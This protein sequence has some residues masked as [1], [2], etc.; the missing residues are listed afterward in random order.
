M[1]SSR[2]KIRRPESAGENPEDSPLKMV[3]RKTIA[4]ALREIADPASSEADR[5]RAREV[6][7]HHKIQFGVEEGKGA[8]HA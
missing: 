6:L 5:Q 8:G 7:E 3:I 4:K 2:K 1:R